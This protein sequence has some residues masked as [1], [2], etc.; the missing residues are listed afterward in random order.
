MGNMGTVVGPKVGQALNSLTNNQA[1]IQGVDYPA[2]AAGNA[3]MGA[4]GG[5]KMASLVETAL[6]QCPDTKVVLGGYSQGAMVV[7][8]AAGKLSS[9]QVVGA[10]TFGDPFKAQKPSNIDQFK[11]FCASGDPV[12]LNGANVMAH[13]SY[14]DDAQTAAQFLVS[15][16][17]L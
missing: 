14:G 10:V 15:A 2:D 6:K 16:A 1:A 17:G 8:N 5:P 3:N 7:H 4:S 12:C 13:L 9:G 11:T